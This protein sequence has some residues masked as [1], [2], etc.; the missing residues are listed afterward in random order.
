MDGTIKGK[1]LW[2]LVIA[3]LILGGSS[4]SLFI[5]M[6][7][8]D[9]MD[10][11]VVMNR[12]PDAGA[13][14]GADNSIPSF[15]VN[16]SGETYGTGYGLHDD[17]PDL[18]AAIG[19]DGTAGYV[20]TA[21][22]FRYSSP[23]NPEEALFFEQEKLRLA[24]E[25]RARG[26]L[27]YNYTIPLYEADGRTV[28]GEFGVGSQYTPGSNADNIENSNENDTDS[29]LL[30]VESVSIRYSDSIR[31]EFTMRVGERVPLNVRIEPLGLNISGDDIMWWASSNRNV[32]HAIPN[33]P[34]S[35]NV[36]VIAIAVGDAVLTVNVDG[37]I[38]ECLIR[39]REP[40]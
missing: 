25:T 10:K 21:D 3:A 8:Q 14:A 1:L 29:S 19:I 23:A 2:V 7:S 17:Y 13:I 5:M 33:Y 28:I 15:Q 36:T 22:L 27:L 6:V 26:I 9:A 31:T 40:R 18:T 32:M 20:R 38:A 24:E 37:V 30:G 11:E 4:I 34:D 39:V 35:T 12:V 16:E